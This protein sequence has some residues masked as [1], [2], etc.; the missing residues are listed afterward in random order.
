MGL[1]YVLLFVSDGVHEGDKREKRRKNITEKI[2]PATWFP[3]LEPENITS[4]PAQEETSGEKR[5]FWLL[6]RP[7]RPTFYFLLKDAFFKSQ[8]HV[9]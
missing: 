9:V 4:A 8:D 7:M 2:N 1:V 3:M 6:H 5:Y